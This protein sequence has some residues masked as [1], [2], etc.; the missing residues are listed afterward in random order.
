VV[1]ATGALFE[2]TAGAE[3]GGAVGWV[4]EATESGDTVHAARS[5]W[6]PLIVASVAVSL[7]NT[8]RLGMFLAAPPESLTV[9]RSVALVKP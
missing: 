3:A 1:V 8:R 7:R 2:L 6:L 9:A 5:N 4:V